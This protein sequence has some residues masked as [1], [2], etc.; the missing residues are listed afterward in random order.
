MV[1]SQKPKTYYKTLNILQNYNKIKKSITFLKDK[2]RSLEKEKDKLS[3][4]IIK[5]DRVVLKDQTQ[6]YYYTDETL[7]NEIN[8]T[9]QLLIKTEKQ[10]EFIDNCIRELKDEQYYE[11]IDSFFKEKKSATFISIKLGISEATFYR[12]KENLI[13]NLSYLLF[14]NEKIN[15]QLNEKIVRKT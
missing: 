15:E 1:K 9:R 8:E 2:V 3:E 6:N 12:S 7:E 14:P 10:I 13:F 5:S 11:I 4:T